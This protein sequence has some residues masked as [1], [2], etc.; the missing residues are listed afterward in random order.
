[1][2]KYV[3]FVIIALSIGFASCSDDDEIPNPKLEITSETG[4]DAVA[5]LD[6]LYLSATTDLP[7]V[8]G[9]KWTVD[10]TEVSKEATYI[11]LKPELL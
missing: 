9:Y 5:Q 11:T 10:D 4:E 7:K 3:A 1:M 6:T 8:N 2:K